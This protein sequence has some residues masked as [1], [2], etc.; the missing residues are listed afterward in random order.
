MMMSA[1]WIINN[2]DD[3]HYHTQGKLRLVTNILGVESFPYITD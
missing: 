2:N 3:D 1:Q